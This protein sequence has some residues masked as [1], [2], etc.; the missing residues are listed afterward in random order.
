MGGG[1]RQRWPIWLSSPRA[2]AGSAPAAT[3]RLPSLVAPCHSCVLQALR[4][5]RYPAPSTHAAASVREPGLVARR[6][7]AAQGGCWVGLERAAQ[8]VLPCMP[9][10]LQPGPVLGPW[11]PKVVALLDA[12]TWQQSSLQLRPSLLPQ[13]HFA[14]EWNELHHLQVSRRWAGWGA[15]QTMPA[16][17]GAGSICN[18]RPDPCARALVWP[19]VLRRTTQ[20]HA[21]YPHSFPCHTT[22]PNVHNPFIQTQSNPPSLRHDL[23]QIMEALGGDLRWGDRFLAEHAA[24]FY[25]WVLVAIYLISPSA[26]YQFMEM[27]EVG[28]PLLNTAGCFRPL[29]LLHRRD[30]RLACAHD[31]QCGREPVLGSTLASPCACLRSMPPTRTLSLRSRTRRRCRASRRRWWP[32]TT[33]RWGDAVDG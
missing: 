32:S 21:A 18:Q 17:G 9:C 3:I 28:A 15:L 4:T 31:W 10:Q 11:H 5:T 8:P 12:L 13:V 24:V 25:Y 22:H 16:G 33:T 1:G 7:R 2:E 23:A 14:E 26:S 29:V 30:T 6:R 20:R 19:L 27:V